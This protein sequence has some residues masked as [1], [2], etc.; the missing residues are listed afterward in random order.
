MEKQELTYDEIFARLDATN[1]TN[2]DIIVINGGEPLTHS[3]F[4]EIIKLAQTYSPKKIEI[5]TNGSL[6]VS[7]RIKNVDK[8]CFIIPIHGEKCTHESIVRVSGVYDKTLKNINEINKIGI[9]YNVKFIIN[10]EM[11]NSS[12]NIADFLEKKELFPSAIVLA[13]MNETKKSKENKVSIPNKASIKKYITGQK[14]LLSSTIKFI[15]IP[16]CLL[17]IEQNDVN[18]AEIPEFYFNDINHF[19]ERKRYYKNLL[20]NKRCS[21]CKWYHECQIMS[22]SYLTLLRNNNIWEIAAE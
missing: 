11:I 14:Q 21:T 13:R 8:L 7:S 1:I 17:E 16:F 10:S 20:I 6:L 9:D 2:Q 5:Y 19:M 18:I 15:Y 4:Y 22:S 12:F 3:K